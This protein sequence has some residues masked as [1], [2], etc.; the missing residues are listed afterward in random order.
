MGVDDYVLFD[1]PGQVE[2]FTHHG[3]LRRIFAR[4]EKMGYRVSSTLPPNLS[5]SKQ[6]ARIML[7]IPPEFDVAGGPPFNRLLHSHAAL[8][9]HIDRPALVARHAADGPAAPERADQ[10]RQAGQLR[11]SPVQP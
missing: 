4:I 9:V 7:T 11:S 1:C 6:E 10:N 2:L 5:A 3:S 8:T